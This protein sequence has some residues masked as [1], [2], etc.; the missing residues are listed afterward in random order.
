MNI[1]KAELTFSDT[2]DAIY[3]VQIKDF[4]HKMKNWPPAEVISTKSFKVQNLYM[5]LEIYP[6]GQKDVNRGYVSA[7]LHND[8]TKPTFL[9]FKFQVGNLQEKH[10]R[11]PFKP[12]EGWGNVKICDHAIKF[13]DFKPDEDIQITCT[14]MKLTMD[15]VVWDMYL[16][17]EVHKATLAE[18]NI[19]LNESKRKHDE[20]NANLVETHTKLNETNA[21]LDEANTKLQETS[22]ILEET[23]AKF[24]RM[25]NRL[26]TRFARMEAKLE[27]LPVFNN[28]GYKLKKP[29]CPVCFEDMS[30]DTKIAQCQNGHHICWTCREKM[31]KKDCSLCGLPI[32]GRAFGME[33]YL[34]SLFGFE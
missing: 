4:H 16:E 9:S 3:T 1:T 24:A 29:P 13:P 20:T 32:D 33:S 7:Y 27:E 12:K 25:E 2:G 5:H 17:S 31:V 21:K 11:K 10:L 28:N 22:S 6:N 18:T 30:F 15:K 23:K 34:R 14:I 19:K 8:T 26:E